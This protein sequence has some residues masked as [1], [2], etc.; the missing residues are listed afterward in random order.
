MIG[1]HIADRSD[2]CACKHL[3]NQCAP[4]PYV[5]E[6]HFTT[7]CR[8][9]FRN[10]SKM[11]NMSAN[12]ACPIDVEDPINA[13]ILAVSEDQ[14]QGFWRDPISELANRIR[15]WSLIVCEPC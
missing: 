9:H 12:P 6:N 15:R 3:L 10:H 11:I 13:R 4:L 7:I 14:L 1:K 8:R 2:R 5:W